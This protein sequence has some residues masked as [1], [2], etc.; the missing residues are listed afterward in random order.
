MK[1]VRFAHDAK[2][3]RVSRCR[4]FT[5]FELM[6]TIAVAAII[7][8]FA[9]PSFNNI[10]RNNRIVTD[11][12]QMISALTLARSEAIRTGNRVTVCRSADQATC[13][14]T[15]G[16]EQGWI[17]FRDPANA[18][19]VDSGEEIVRVWDPLDGGTT[20]RAASAFASY[21]SFVGSGETRGDT[22]NTGSFRVCGDTADIAQGRTIS[23]GLIGYT[24]TTKGVTACP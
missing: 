8:G 6:L 22:G 16:W 17:V 10:L 7:A 21:V 11:N 20:I 5:L 18:G 1:A 24:S 12:N 3:R 14:T 23:V 9:A 2:T 19:T 4:G 13:A 15:G